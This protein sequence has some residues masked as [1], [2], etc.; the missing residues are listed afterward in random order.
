VKLRLDIHGCLAVES[1]VAI[2]EQEVVEEV[3]VLAAPAKADT[4]V[5]SA[6][7]SA[8]A[9][10]PPAEGAAESEIPAVDGA[11]ADAGVAEAPAEPP[12]ELP[13]VET[14]KTKKIKRV[15]LTVTSKGTGITPTELMEA[16]EAEGQMALLDKIIQQT[17]E[18]MNALEAAVYRLRDES[19]TKLADFLTEADRETLSAM[20][21]ATEDWLYED[22]MDVDKAT[23]EAKL[24]ELNAAFAPGVQ[25]EKEAEE[26]PDAFAEL[27]KTIEKFSAF[28]ASQSE[29]YG[30][31]GTEQKQ[32]V[33]AE[34][35]TVQAWLADSEAQIKATSKTEAAPVK[36]ADIRSKAQELS[37][38]CQPIMNTPKPLPMEPE[39]PATEEPSSES[40]PGDQAPPVGGAVPEGK[41]APA[42]DGATAR[43]AP[44][45]DNMDVD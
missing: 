2:E 43:D 3:P 17:A 27:T 10:E 23:Y 37:A 33:A 34:C 42:S 21:T 14:K 38:V 19:S 29:E 5:P 28:A 24:K 30:H 41:A 44:K 7:S 13:K 25:R 35:A 11:V 4:P 16:Q 22:G 32:M 18:A 20:C 15:P 36:P 26:R 12:A 39:K 40:A 6:D 8:P 1:A 31:I 45:P 9:T